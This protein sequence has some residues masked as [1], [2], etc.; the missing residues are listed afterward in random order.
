LAKKLIVGKTSFIGNELAKLK[1]Y[2]IVAYKDIHHVDFS[3]YDGVINCALNPVFKTQTY[4]EKIDVDYEMA[5]LAYENNCHYIMISTRKVYGSSTKLKT[6]NEES[7]TNPF[8]FYSEN[9]LICE[10]KILNEFG[11]RAVIVR[12]SNLFGFELGRQSFMGFCIDQLKHSEKI[13][14]S[15]GENTKR[16][17]IDIYTS[18]FLLDSISRKKLTGIYNL[19]SN[20]GLEIGKVAKSLIRGYGKGEFSCTSDVVKEQFI[21]DNTKLTEE[22]RVFFNPIYI[23]SIIEDLGKKLCKI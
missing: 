23:T 6:Y 5:K 15:I 9:K 10:N 4:D 18:S 17:F 11:D 22:L 21:I 7:P 16:D 3:Q 13:I 1:N 19:S 12:G 20:H 2:D 14:F 8:D